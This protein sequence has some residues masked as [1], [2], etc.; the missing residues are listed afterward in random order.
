VSTPAA[1]PTTPFRAY[2]VEDGVVGDFLG[3][4]YDNI[5]AVTVACTCFQTLQ[6]YN[7][8]TNISVVVY[9]ENDQIIAWIGRYT[10]IAA[11]EP[12]PARE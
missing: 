12:L 9:D 8:R 3:G 1:P 7:P 6:G 4:S 5:S 11:L 2:K 10:P